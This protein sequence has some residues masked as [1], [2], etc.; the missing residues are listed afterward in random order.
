M[1][2]VD[3]DRI[4]T[5]QD[6]DSDVSILR[7]Q[8][9]N[10][11]DGAGKDRGVASERVGDSREQ[12]QPGR[13]TGGL[14]QDDER[15]A[16]QQLAVE[17]PGAVEAG[18]LGVL[19]RGAELCDDA[20]QLIEFERARRLDLDLAVVGEGFTLDRQRGRKPR[21]ASSFETY[22]KS[23]DRARRLVRDL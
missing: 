2:H 13:V 6:V 17:D 4:A 15:V 3:L 22:R 8:L 10:R 23:V 12:R 14:P 16:R 7:R 19:G 11:L 18:G 5:V 9:L 1:I 20:G 21:L